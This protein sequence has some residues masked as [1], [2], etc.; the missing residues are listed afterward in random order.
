MANGKKRRSFA[1]GKD[2][3]RWAAS[4]EVV[5]DNSDKNGHNKERR[6]IIYIIYVR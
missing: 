3:C 5:A 4:I 2:R 6:I 1:I